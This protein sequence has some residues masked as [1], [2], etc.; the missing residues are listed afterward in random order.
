MLITIEMK[1]EASTTQPPIH[2]NVSTFNSPKISDVIDSIST[3]SICPIFM[4]NDTP[5]AV[6][7]ENTQK[8][9]SKALI[10]AS[11]HC[12]YFDSLLS[13]FSNVSINHHFYKNIVFSLINTDHV[14]HTITFLTVQ[15]WKMWNF[16]IYLL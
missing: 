2:F 9:S 6:F 7:V 5:Q 16:A 13:I 1:N 11:F 3:S 15:W 4:L 14:N 12:H 10:Y 8:S